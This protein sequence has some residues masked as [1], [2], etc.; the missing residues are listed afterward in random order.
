LKFKKIENVHQI[1]DEQLKTGTEVFSRFL[2]EGQ[3]QSLL[4]PFPE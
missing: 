3:V 1:M 4:K 2:R